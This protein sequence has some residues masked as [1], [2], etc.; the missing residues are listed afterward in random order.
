ML[1]NLFYP[2]AKNRGF[3]PSIIERISEK[4]TNALIK[5]YKPLLIWSLSHKWLVLILFF[6]LL[7]PGFYFLSNTGSEFLPKADDGLITCKVILPTGTSM[8]KT[9][10]VLTKISK[11]IE[12]QKYIHGFATLAGG[13]VWGLVTTEKGF[14]GEI[15]IELVPGSQRP[16]NTDEYVSKLRPIIMKEVKGL[17]GVV[18]VFHNKMKGIRRTGTF[19]IEIEITAPQSESL[20]DIYNESMKIYKLLKPQEYLRGLDLSIM[21]TKPEYQISIDRQKAASM[22]IN[23]EELAETIKIFVNGV[24]STFYK[25][26][27]YYYPIR[28]VVEESNIQNV[29]DLENLFIQTRFGKKIP[30]YSIAEITATTGPV[31]IDR[32]NQDRLIKVTANVSKISVGDATNKI[33]ETLNELDLPLG[34][35]LNYGGQSQM[36]AE[37]MQQMILILLFALFLGYAVLVLYFESFLKPLIMIIRIPLSLAGMSIA[38][39]I[40]NT[41][42]SVTAIIGVIMLTGIEINNGVLLITFADELKKQGYKTIEAVK[43]AAIVRFRPIII[44]NIICIAALIPIAFTLHSGTEMLQPMGIVMIGGLVNGLL[45]IFFFVP[46]IYS[47][48]FR[49]HNGTDKDTNSEDKTMNGVMINNARGNNNGSIV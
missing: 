36:L 48:F 49:D 9:D 39:Y 2:E 29:S 19:D 34:Y 41:P 17:N 46:V 27:V 32:K 24:V 33:K 25:E 10:A 44:T 22:G 26:E 3:K 13:K 31:Q 5:L 35:R 1:M 23:L 12:N 7:I 6:L 45:L 40:T 14:E 11:I 47:M 18:K 28:L 37:N 15:N 43:E 4:F 38:L 16:M 30:L 21:L 8:E 20:Q 42:L